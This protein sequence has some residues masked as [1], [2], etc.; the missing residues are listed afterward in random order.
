MVGGMLLF[1]LC[2]D[3]N[4]L[5]VRR[6]GMFLNCGFKTWSYKKNDGDDGVWPNRMIGIV[7]R[8][9]DRPSVRKQL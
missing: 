4:A 7:D 3:T 2:G 9:W 8:Y 6:R 1:A 5:S